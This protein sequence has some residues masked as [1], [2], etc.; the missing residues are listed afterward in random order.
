MDGQL[1]LQG[2]E[3]LLLGMSIV[4]GFLILLVFLLRGMSGLAA[5]FEP[6]PGSQQPVPAPVHPVDQG[7]AI[8]AIS[9]AVA[10][11]RASRRA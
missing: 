3:L 1:L 8:A 10:K 6:S 2:F 9:I 5:R 7:P 4:F 11:Y